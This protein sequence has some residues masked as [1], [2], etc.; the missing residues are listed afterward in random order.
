MVNRVIRH[1]IKRKLFAFMSLKSYRDKLRIILWFVLRLQNGY[2]KINLVQ[3]HLFL[4]MLLLWARIVLRYERNFWYITST[5]CWSGSRCI[6]STHL[7]AARLQRVQLMAIARNSWK[8]A[9][10]V[11]RISIFTI[12]FSWNEIDQ[13]RV[14]LTVLDKIAFDILPL[15]SQ[16]LRTMCPPALITS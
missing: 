8:Y 9:R 1:H 13:M 11:R 7:P 14:A 5:F 10:W 6:L 3:L 15:I 16:L 12:S 2:V 4:I